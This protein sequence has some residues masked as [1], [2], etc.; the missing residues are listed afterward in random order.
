MI[1]N[2]R[3]P[4]IILGGVLLVLASCSDSI[5]N[6]S[7]ELFSD[8]G[9]SPSVLEK[10][11]VGLLP[12]VPGEGTRIQAAEV[13]AILD[14]L[15]EQKVRPGLL[16]SSREMENRINH[17]RVLVAEW[18]KIAPHISVHSVTGLERTRP[19]GRMLGLRFLLETQ[20]QMAEEAGG[21]EQVRIFARIFDTV[22]GRIVW[23]GVGEGRGY[24][25]LF[26]PSVPATF[27]E[28]ASV[29]AK[30]L[31]AKIFPD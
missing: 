4:S 5:N 22:R 6:L 30:G 29:A 31:I 18:A 28:T 9:F 14:H 7:T 23:E 12:T 27:K 11:G 3:L 10:E 13:S 20:I 1:L 15:F 19:F 25:K 16:H 17:D 26:F 24:V 8:E 2:R 21:A